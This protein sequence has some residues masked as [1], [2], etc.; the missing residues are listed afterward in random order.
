MVSLEAFNRAAK[1]GFISFDSDEMQVCH[2]GAQ[3]AMKITTELNSSYHTPEEVVEIF[4]KLTGCA[5]PDSFRCFPP[6][7]TDFGKNIHLGEN[8]FINAGCKF[9]DQGGVYIGRGTHIGHN[10]V[11]AT[12]NHRED[13]RYRADLLPKSVVI[14]EDCWIGSNAT[15]LPGVT[16]GNGAIIGA[17]AVVAKDI[18]AEM[19]AA[20]VPA[21]IIRKIKIE[22]EA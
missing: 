21:R 10:V 7:Y 22:D 11:I 15:I 17:G 1:A 6:F 5:V 19:V 16:I 8:V 12:L 18:P 2:I 3:E 4:R 20:G 14:G 13:P 9:Q